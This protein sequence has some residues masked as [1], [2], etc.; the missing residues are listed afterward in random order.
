M[1]FDYDQ[2]FSLSIDSTLVEVKYVI[3]NLEEALRCGQGDAGFM[4]GVLYSPDNAILSKP[5]M[6]ALG[7]SHEKSKECLVSGYSHLIREASAGNGRSMHLIAIYYQGGL[8]PVSHDI[9]QYEYWKEKAID[10]GY[11]GS[12]QL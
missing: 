1:E 12:G 6:H 8:P 2:F 4:L 9:A 10:A 11:R 3:K 7:A 5:V